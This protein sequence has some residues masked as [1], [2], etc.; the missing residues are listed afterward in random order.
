MSDRIFNE[1]EVQKLIKRAAELEAERS[2]SGKDSGRNGL[3]IDELKA[4]ASEAGLDPELIV[5][6]AL[7]LDSEQTH[8]KERVRVN[9]EEISSE[10]W[11]DYQPS[12]ET[13]DLLVTELN[14]MYGTTDELNWW[15]NLWGTHEGKAKV[16]KTASTT[17]WDY[18]TEAGMYSTRVLMQRRGD[19]F[20]IRVS[21]RRFMGL[22]WG[23]SLN[24]L[25]PLVPV[26]VVFAVLGGLTSSSVLGIEWPGITAGLLLA[27]GCYPIVRFL[28]KQF[29]KKHKNEVAETARQ[30]SDFV[31]QSSV[32]K[33]KESSSGKSRSA[34]EIEIPDDNQDSDVQ[35]FKLR[36]NLRE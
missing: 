15:D 16:T 9:R 33:S 24:Y 21:K 4:V 17:E 12:R 22:E 35:S 13:V 3:T 34:S 27:L 32:S 14:H 30:L 20:R 31:L 23:N 29:L 19:R 25:I 10:V 36:N 2:V 11:L 8:P 26:A 7:E 6:A 1:G 18:K 5:K 28:T